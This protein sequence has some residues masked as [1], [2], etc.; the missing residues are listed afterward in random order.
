MCPHPKLS[1]YDPWE[2]ASPIKQDD[3]ELFFRCNWA[4]P[5]EDRQNLSCRNLSL[6]E[7]AGGGK[8]AGHVDP[9][10]AST[11]FK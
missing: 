11:H 1:S 2:S 5:C 4:I 8:G 7:G 3:G 6:V 9:L 10:A